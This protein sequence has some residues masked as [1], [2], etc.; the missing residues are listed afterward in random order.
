MIKKKQIIAIF[1]T[2]FILTE[3]SYSKDNDKEIYFIGNSLDV[4]TNSTFWTTA[5]VN[6]RTTIY[7]EIDT[8]IADINFI[9]YKNEW[10]GADTI[11]LNFIA[12]IVK[13]L[14]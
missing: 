5:K 1:L 3:S 2:L 9:L 7:E 10:A 6:F 11:K 13:N 12:D 8:E 14:I 4:A